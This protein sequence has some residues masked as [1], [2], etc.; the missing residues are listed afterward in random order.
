MLETEGTVLAKTGLKDSVN[1]LG[2]VCDQKTSIFF[3]PCGR[4]HGRT[5]RYKGNLLKVREQKYKREHGGQQVQSAVRECFS[6]SGT[7]KTYANLWEGR[8]QVIP[9]PIINEW[10]GAWWFPA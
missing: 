5:H 4:I 6:F 9:H 7:F 8:N 2:S 1:S 10:V 3:V